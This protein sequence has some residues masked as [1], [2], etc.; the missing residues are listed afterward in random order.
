[1]EDFE[2]S[3][4]AVGDLP[5]RAQPKAVA[6]QEAAPDRRYVGRQHGRVAKARKWRAGSKRWNP[7]S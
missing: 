2:A 5:L 6:I 3:V 7:I 4:G 1:M